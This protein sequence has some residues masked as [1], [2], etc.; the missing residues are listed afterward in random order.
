[1]LDPTTIAAWLGILITGA[2]AIAGFIKFIFWAYDQWQKRR[3]HEGFSAPSE[4]L[5]LATKPEGACWWHMGKK[6]DEPT[7]QI[8]G[9][10]FA[11]NIASV[12]VR[13]PQVELRY[14][15][16][17]RK[18]A[19]GMVMV[20]RTWRENMY[21]MYDIPP[22]ET[23][24]VSFDFWVYPPVAKPLDP[25][26]SRCVT[27]IDQFGNRHKLNRLRF[28]STAA[29]SAPKPKEPEEFPYEIADP[30]EKEIVSVLKA[31]LGRYQI[32]GRSC[33]GL[34]SV[35]IV[36]Q[37]RPFTGVGS[38]SWT[39]NSPLNQVIVSNPEAAALRS[40]NMDALVAFHQRLTSDEERARFVLALLDRLDPKRGYLSISYFIVSVL[41]SVGS[42]PQ[43]LQKA[44]RDLPSGETRVFGLSNVLMLLNGLLKYR[45]PD[46]TNAMLDEIERMIHGLDEH[47]FLIPSKIA[48]IRANRL[49]S[50]A[51][52]PQ[53]R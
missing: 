8:V 29:D 53:G 6:G 1:M 20:A 10:I 36:Y 52:A 27:I 33:G 22:G 31:E 30:I 43:A 50:T 21:G 15:F 24:D 41:F 4:T 7:M 17:G 45:H 37:D 16:L 12:P 19:S 35:H 26:T 14:G 42:L 13:I 25:F 44:R 23:R 34:G 47:Q 32:C 5:R 3:K 49:T 18:R 11:T 2:G 46:F 38:D 39:P 48:A 40:D 9:S 28:R 51:P